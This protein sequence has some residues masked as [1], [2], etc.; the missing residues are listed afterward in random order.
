[1]SIFITKSIK[2]LASSQDATRKACAQW[3]R[4]MQYIAKCGKDAIL[5]RTNMGTERWNAYAH[6]S[7]K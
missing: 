3:I 6:P 5:D 1:M 4:K 2:S 7:E